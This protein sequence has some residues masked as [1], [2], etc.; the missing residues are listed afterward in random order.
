LSHAALSAK[1]VERVVVVVPRSHL[2]RQVART[3][4]EAGGIQLDATFDSSAGKVTSDFDGVA[5]TYQQV[6]YNPEVFARLMAVRALVIFDEIHHCGEN[7]AWSNAMHRAF[8]EATY[9]L[10]MSGT[11][12]RSDRR[13][14]PFVRYENHLCVPDI[15]YDYARALREGVCRPIAFPLLSGSAEW[16]SR[17]GSHRNVRFDEAIEKQ[18]EAERLRTA[19]SQR[20]WL[21]AALQKAH[22]LLQSVRRT[23]DRGAGG[24]VLALDQDHAREVGRLMEEVLGVRPSVVISDDDKSDE[25][26]ARFRESR[27]EW[28]VAVHK[29]S[30]GIDIPR[31]RVLVWASA[32]ATQLYFLQAVGRIVR[33][34]P[35]LTSQQR[36][37]MLLPDVARMKP[38]VDSVREQVLSFVKE[39]KKPKNRGGASVNEGNDG[40]FRPLGAEMVDEGK[41]HHVDSPGA[42]DA[43]GTRRFAPP[44]PA[45]TSDGTA[46]P[47]ASDEMI[48]TTE[49]RERIRKQVNAMVRAVSK[50]FRVSHGKVHGTLNRRCGATLATA[51]HAQLAH[52]ARETARWLR[53]NS[54][55]GIM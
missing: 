37:Y 28:M 9:R 1:L 44:E 50:Q 33:M 46:M 6:A 39:R 14:I 7:A 8:D 23:E 52:R 36:A 5:I 30:E 15:N 41:V 35:E 32:C 55:D 3:F 53:S 21:G 11:P 43:A 51:T 18:Y 38:L 4:S 31:L 40:L 20:G 24:L 42:A 26:I 47:A 25:Y 49:R 29:V 12:F 45:G 19:F 34:Q 27:T 16:V 13:A 10:G 22:G 2:K 48:P 17:D 54:Y